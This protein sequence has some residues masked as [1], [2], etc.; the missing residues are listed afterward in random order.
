MHPPFRNLIRGKGVTKA[1]QRI[2]EVIGKVLPAS[3]PPRVRPTGSTGR[4]RPPTGY[5]GSDPPREAHHKRETHTGRPVTAP[6]EY[7]VAVERE[8]SVNPGTR[9]QR[10]TLKINERL[11]LPLREFAFQ[12]ARSGGPGGQHV[13]KV[14]S[15]V[16]LRF[17]VESSATLSDAQKDR[18]LRR[19]PARFLNKEG[20]IVVSADEHRDQ[21]RNKERCL[22]KLRELLRSALA[23][24]KVRVPTR[25]SRGAQTRRKEAKQQHS[26]KKQ[27]RR[28]RFE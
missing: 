4:V 11:E 18:I 26:R 7:P 2:G 20:E 24:P 23:K 15:K 5:Q 3:V 12:A 6:V 19:V 27:D 1:W 10:V 9:A 25:I 17:A 8:V 13:N 21:V 16:I 14:S 22:E 28:Q